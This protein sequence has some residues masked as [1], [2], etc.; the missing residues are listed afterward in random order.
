MLFATSLARLAFILLFICFSP[1]IN[2]L[3]HL[4]VPEPAVLCHV[5]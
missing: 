5:Q 3:G 1:R 2:E 4:F